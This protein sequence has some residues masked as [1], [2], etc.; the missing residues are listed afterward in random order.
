MVVHN[1]LAGR[2]LPYGAMEKDV[3]ATERN[4]ARSKDHYERK[5]TILRS[6]KNVPR[7]RLV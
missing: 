5:K 3:S 6:G 2:R 4:Y 1:L 7:A